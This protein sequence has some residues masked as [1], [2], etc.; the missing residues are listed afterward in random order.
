E[1]AG[2]PLE[3]AL[4]AA[5]YDARRVQCASTWNKLLAGGMTLDLPEAVV[6]NAWR[7]VLIG[8]YSL[9]T[10]DEIRYSHGNQYAKL[11][12]GE[13][14]DAARS[15]MLYGQM[16]S[17]GRMIRPLFVYTRKKLEFHQAAFKLQMLAHYHRL[18][19]DA[20][21]LE[22][23]R[24]LWQKEID[25]ILKGRERKTGMLPREKYCGDID[26]M[27]YS[28]NSNSNC[29]RALRDMSIVLEQTGDRARATKLAKTAAEYRRT[30]LASLETAIQRDVRPPFV[31]IA[32]SGEE[33]AY[34]F[35]PGTR[36][37]GYWNIMIQYVLGSGVFR[38]NSPV[39][40]DLLRYLQ[41]RGGLVMGLLSTHAESTRYWMAERKINDLYGMRYALA[42]LERDE[43][44]RALAGFYAKLAHGFT[45]D[46]FICAEGS[47]IEP[48]DEFG[49]LMYL[50]PNSAGNASFLQQLRYLL[51]Q[52]E[53]LDDDGR[54]ET[55][56][57]L[58][59]TPRPWLADG[60][61]IKVDRAPT[62][63]G[64]T[65]VNVESKLGEGRVVAEVTLPAT[66]PARTLLRLRLP[67]GWRI[68]SAG[69]SGQM[70]KITNAE[71]LD[72]SGLSGV[73]Q[74]QANVERK[75]PP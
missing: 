45:R 40:D 10:G 17:A 53:D 72:L 33:T 3:P 73:I 64:E 14:G 37:G 25:V 20:P 11:Y 9:L 48:L 16:P 23:H 4:N 34:E 32:L 66:A 54:A 55:L 58:F 41:Q 29:W 69:A 60:K 22:Q 30:I 8:S 57:L 31:P 44:D 26:T 63:F 68:A 5:S 49:R 42:L 1:P 71:T 62:A 6:N 47:D 67:A 12:I 39:A 15:F 21:F 52:D 74:V 43:P 19:R 46:T 38:S 7:A 50:P 65:S 28:L 35:I 18:T 2:A 13:G 36:M 61:R 75:P 56:R 27:V 59:A 51:V 24:P 70:L